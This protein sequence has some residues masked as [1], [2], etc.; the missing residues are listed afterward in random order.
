VHNRNRDDYEVA[1]ALHE[2]GL[3]EMLVTDI[4][5]PDR[6]G[7]RVCGW[8]SRRHRAGLPAAKVRSDLVSFAL[9]ALAAVARL[10]GGRVF[11]I[12]DGRLARRAARLARARGSGLYAYSSYVDDRARETAP[13]IDFEYHPHPALALEILGADLERF[14]AVRWSFE[15]EA[16]IAG[17]GS[18]SQA[19][20]RAD[21]VVCASGMTRRS[22]EHA[23][24]P[25]AKITVVPY[26]CAPA[27]GAVRTRPA[28]PCRFLFV[29]QGV[30]R[31][32]LHHL[33]LAWRAAA[34]PEAELVVA[35]Y[36]I[37]PGIGPLLD[38]PGITLLGRQ[39]RAALDALFASADVF[40]MPSLVEGFGLVYLE[41]LAG[42][43]HVIGTQNSGLPDLPLGPDAATVVPPGD[44]AALAAALTDLAE[45]KR[46]GR[47]DPAAIR[48]EGARWTWADFRGGIARH[49]AAVLGQGR[50]V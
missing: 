36:L 50:P 17:T 34:L 49:A 8:F 31:K 32:G 19:W 42:G 29:G 3:L 43:C 45:R 30:Q 4:Y 18:I 6:L 16:A 1:L 37:D 35:S 41:A 12:V 10:P 13:V 28:G 20:R 23:G 48:A 24:C 9:Q 7:G 21:A 38:Q 14:P 15:R 40:V 39:D 2:A 47:L 44:I 11:G 5:R 22:L 33:A 25:S 26:A 46:S 27:S